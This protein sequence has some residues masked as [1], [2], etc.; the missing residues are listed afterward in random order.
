MSKN[1]KEINPMSLEIIKNAFIWTSKEMSKIMEQSAYT[2]LFSEAG[3]F[4]TVIMDEKAEIIAQHSVQA[5]QL[6]AMSLTVSWTVAEIGL[7][8]IKPGDILFQNDSYKG[9]THVPEITIV[10]P[11]FYKGELIGFAGNMAHLVDIG[12]IAPGGFPPHATD[13]FQ[14]GIRIPPVKI[15]NRGKP[16]KEIIKIFLNNIRIPEETEGDI[17]AMIASVL[18]GEKRV[19]YYIDKYGLNTIKAFFQEVKIYSEKKIRTSIKEIPDGNYEGEDYM[20]DDGIQDKPVKV[21]VSIIKRGD[22]LIVDYSGS[23]KQ[24]EGPIN[25]TWAVTHSATYNAIMHLTDPYVPINQGCFRPIKIIAPMGLVVNVNYPGSIVGGHTEFSNHIVYSIVRAMANVMPN[26]VVGAGPDSFH[27]FFGGGYNSKNNR[28]Y[29]FWWGSS[30]GNGGRAT[31]DGNDAIPAIIG[32]TRNFPV[33]TVEI[34]YPWMIEEVKLRTD[35]GGAGK[36]RGGLGVERRY[37]LLDSE[38]IVGY[39]SD[40]HKIPP[41]GIFG[42]KPGSPS[43]VLLARSGENFKN[44]IEHGIVF[45]T[46][47]MNLKLF[48]G[49]VIIIKST[50]GGGYGNPFE[51]DELNVLRDVQMKYI[52]IEKAKNDYGVVFNTDNDKLKVDLEATKKMRV[53]LKTKNKNKKR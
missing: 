25:C 36:Y 53:N 21:K 50:G 27:N 12:G 40:R 6:G 15:W 3:D 7:E 18:A 45:P 38:A 26:K 20:D 2:P 35:S 33:E 31:K 24:T 44:I 29:A 17:S 41:W 51:R 37:R 43:E 9:G 30:G 48:K 39:F 49:D 4:A 19:L 1:E 14:E 10:R 28:Y 13:I 16:A 11:I 22:R 34:R 52:S 5:A 46:K 23:S 8:N 42:G 47:F 32:N